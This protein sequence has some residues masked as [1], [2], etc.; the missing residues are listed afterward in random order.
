M[1]DTSQYM[2][3]RHEKLWDLLIMVAL[4]SMVFLVHLVM[5]W[6]ATIFNLTPDEYSVTAVA[7]YITGQDWSST[8]STG[9]YYG[10]FQSL[11]YIPAFLLTDEPYLRYKLMLCINALL[12]SL[13]PVIVYHLCRKRFDVER[14]A[15]VIF[16]VICGAYPCYLLLTKYTWNETMCCLLPW[17]FFLLVFKAEGCDNTVKKQ[18]LSILGGIVLV[19]A[20]A[21]HGR[22]LSLLAAG[23]VG[24]LV[25]HFVLK[26]R[27]F[28]LSGFFISSAAAFVADLLIK[29]HLQE[30]LWLASERSSP[31][32]NTIEKMVA[33][34]FSADAQ[35]IGHFFSTLAGHLYYFITAT[36]GVGPICIVLIIA[37][38]VKHIRCI[39]KGT[40][41][42]TDDATAILSLFAFLMM[43]AVFAVSV[44]FKCTSSLI[45]ERMD[46]AIYGRYTEAFYPV[47]LFAALILIYKGRLTAKACF[48][49]VFT[50]VG[51]NIAA[52]LMT[53]PLVLSGN[54]FVCAMILGI[55]PMRF[56]EGIRTLLTND[57]FILLTVANMAG[58]T[59]FVLMRLIFAKFR[60]SYLFVAVPLMAMLAFSSA[61]NYNSY[62]KPQYKNALKGADYMQ[63]AIDP[64]KD[65]FDEL[66][67]VDISKERYVKAQFL[68]PDKEFEIFS[69]VSKLGGLAERP[70]II[71]SNGEDD[72]QLWL[73]GVYALGDTNGK[74]QAYACCDDSIEWA[75]CSGLLRD[76]SGSIHYDALAI[77]DNGVVTR[78]AN[79]VIIPKASSVYTGYSVWYSGASLEITTVG[80]GIGS[81]QI[82]VT[83]DKG[84]T[85]IPYLVS[86]KTAN[87]ITIKINTQKKHE[88]VR[89]ELKNNGF[90][91]IIFE[92]LNI[93][94]ISEPLVL[95]PE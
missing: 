94:R 65:R 59:L 7:A 52:L 62:V 88:N 95:L 68:Y 15:A 56:G 35:A 38:C 2:P 32:A 31:P 66:C 6:D 3:V 36:W 30:V 51:I 16:S 70:E 45:D 34:L 40:E 81:A 79:R 48:G 58:I 18:V 50:A 26:K 9:G 57:T 14:I 42:E 93:V 46:S 13:V 91:P 25:V 37:G 24:V 27:I 29:H 87:S 77:I 17:V 82:S 53:R 20:Y 23:V 90:E 69:D 61:S 19:A 10:Y 64:L 5:L 1:S 74:V 85:D 12:I 63:S 83:A 60:R 44:L 4:Y 76:G 49:S 84:Q 33:R 75:E 11:F 73:D 8:V 67:L 72:L 41:S 47:A 89:I 92:S 55:A 54:R 86:E 80:E 28:S 78:E 43:G 39:G 71:L 22:M 21:T